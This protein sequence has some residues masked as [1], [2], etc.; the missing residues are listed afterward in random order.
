[1]ALFMPSGT[2]PRHVRADSAALAR[3]GA[4]VTR[5]IAIP[6]LKRSCYRKIERARQR[7]A[8]DLSRWYVL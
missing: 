8:R 4:R 6:Y 1:M 7:G 3:A 2:C 5:A